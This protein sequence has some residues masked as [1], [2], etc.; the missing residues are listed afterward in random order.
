MTFWDTTAGNG[1]SFRTHTCDGQ[2]DGT[3]DG[4]TDMEVEIVVHQ[5][6]RLRRDILAAAAV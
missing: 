4:Q 2:T 5:E 1:P 3:M 6:F